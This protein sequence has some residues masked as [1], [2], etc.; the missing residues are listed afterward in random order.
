MKYTVIYQKEGRPAYCVCITLNPDESFLQFLWESFNVREYD[1]MFVFKGHA[2]RI[3]IDSIM[4]E[5]EEGRK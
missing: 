5:E 3:S 4:Y 1:I 2:E